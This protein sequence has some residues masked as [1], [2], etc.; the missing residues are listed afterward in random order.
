VFSPHGLSVFLAA[1]SILAVTA[2]AV[3]LFLYLRYVIN[4]LIRHN[5]NCID[6][7]QQEYQLAAQSL[8]AMGEKIRTIESSIA[9]DQT[10]QKINPT[11]DLATYAHATKMVQMGA[12]ADD[13]MDS[14][15]LSKAEATLV[16]SMHAKQAE[17]L[18]K[19]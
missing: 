10:K 3:L 17:K 16:V 4:P 2:L 5:A 14:C 9:S 13:I 18:E 6:K 12:N 15:G 8:I 1:S 11:K 7:M 19:A